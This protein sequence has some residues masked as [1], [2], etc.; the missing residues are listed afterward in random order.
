[1]FVVGW[2]TVI[3]ESCSVQ[4]KLELPLRHEVDVLWTEQNPQTQHI[5]AQPITFSLKPA[6]SLVPHLITKM[7]P[8]SSRYPGKIMLTSNVSSSSGDSAC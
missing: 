6:P 7:V 2:G 8:P 5:Q 3:P 4:V 1:M